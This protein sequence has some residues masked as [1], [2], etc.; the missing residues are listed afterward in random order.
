MVA[1]GARSLLK[2]GKGGS[3]G[4]LL[5]CRGG[6]GSCLCREGGDRQMPLE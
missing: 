6:E 1:S 5:P 4:L 2:E 3:G